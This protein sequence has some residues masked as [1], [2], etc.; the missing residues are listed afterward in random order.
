MYNLDRNNPLNHIVEANTAV[1]IFVN[2]GYF[3][4]KRTILNLLTI[5]NQIERA[6]DHLKWPFSVSHGRFA[7]YVEP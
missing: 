1:I 2:C 5:V 4:R 6:R 3:L 7:I